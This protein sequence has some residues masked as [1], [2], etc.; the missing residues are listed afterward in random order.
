MKNGFTRFNRI[1]LLCFFA[2]SF[3][4]LTSTSS[5]S[6]RKC[7][8]VNSINMISSDMELTHE[9]KPHGVPG[10]YGWAS[11]SRIGMGNQPGSFRALTAWGQLYEDS[12]GNPAGNARVQIRSMM[13]YVLS[14][15]DRQWHQLQNSYRVEGNA[16]REDYAENVNRPADTRQE[17]DGSISVTAG[18]GYNFHFWPASGRVPIEPDTIAGVFITVQARLIVND[19][20]QPDDRD[21]ARY[22]LSVGG[23]YWSGLNAQWDHFKT[24]NDI[25]IGRFKY[26]RKDWQSFNMSTL[27]AQEIEQNPPPLNCI[28]SPISA[29]S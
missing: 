16:F 9:G 18:A 3:A 15:T 29:K 26:V 4:G 22:L 24:N 10:Y 12:A 7:Q 13:A 11:R 2:L 28:S 19:P 8:Q 17:A 25:G 20:G 14:K 21:Q 5:A 23:D 6:G 1:W 27:S